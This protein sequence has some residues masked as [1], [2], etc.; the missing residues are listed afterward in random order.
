MMLRRLLCL[1]AVA[2]ANGGRAAA[3]EA[4]CSAEWRE[5]R[6]KMEAAEATEAPVDPEEAAG[7]PGGGGGGGGGGA[8]MGEAGEGEGVTA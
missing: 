8:A 4:T 6:A 2:F 5:V 7:Q 1:G 3:Q